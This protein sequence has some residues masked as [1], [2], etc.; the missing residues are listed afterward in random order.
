M[1]LLEK[2]DPT[3]NVQGVKVHAPA[4]GTVFGPNFLV[5]VSFGQELIFQIKFQS[6]ELTLAAFFR[7]PQSMP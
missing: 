2:I 7:E 3:Q 1:P 6:I 5:V 4:N